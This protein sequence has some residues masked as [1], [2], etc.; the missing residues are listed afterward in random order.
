MKISKYI[1]AKATFFIIS[2]ILSMTAL[3]FI[4]T[5]Y[6]IQV[7]DIIVEANGMVFDLIL[8]GVLLTFF[9]AWREKKDKIERL[10]EEIEDYRKW[11][12]KEA[13]YRIEGAIKRLLRLGVYLSDIDLRD[14]YLSE[15]FFEKAISEGVNLRGIILKKAFF[16]STDLQR[17]NLQWVKFQKVHFRGANLQAADFRGAFLEEVEFEGA[18][19]CEANFQAAV[20]EKVDFQRANLQGAF[21]EITNLHDTN[22]QGANLQGASVGIDWFEMTASWNIIG[23]EEIK[24]KY[25]IDEKGVLRLKSI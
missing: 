4:N 25:V 20:L 24:E 23:I 15:K 6:E 18:N 7:K 3:Y 19:L 11:D 2:V 22:F 17:V 14:C 1:T 13:M 21:F 8:L 12:E 9:E 10:R 16:D 5:K